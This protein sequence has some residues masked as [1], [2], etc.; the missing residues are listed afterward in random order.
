LRRHLPLASASAV[1]C[2]ALSSPALT[3][4]AAYAQDKSS[5]QAQARVVNVEA[6]QSADASV[7]E[8]LERVF[9]SIPLSGTPIDRLMRMKGAAMEAPDGIGL[10]FELEGRRGSSDETLSA[11][12]SRSAGLA[13]HRLAMK[14]QATQSQRVV[15]YVHHIAN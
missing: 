8:M 6:S 11:D 15:V 5:I 13:T 7:R 4:R 1:V 3:G 2:L 9:H 10:F 14:K 12:R